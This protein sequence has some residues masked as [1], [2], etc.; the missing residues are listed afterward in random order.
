MA[1]LIPHLQRPMTFFCQHRSSFWSKIATCGSQKTSVDT[2]AIQKCYGNLTH[3]Q[4]LF[5]CCN[6]VV[7]VAAVHADGVV[8]SCC[9]YLIQIYTVYYCKII[10]IIEFYLQYTMK[11]YCMRILNLPIWL[12]FV[13]CYVLH[14]LDAQMT[15]WL[16][17]TKSGYVHPSKVNSVNQDSGPLRLC[18]CLL[19]NWEAL[20]GDEL[21]KGSIRMTAEAGQ[22]GLHC[23]LSAKK[24]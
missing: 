14:A 13:L 9:L 15:R 10:I 17:H 19:W 20:S 18:N 3:C 2:W 16:A 24:K 23:L 11:L 1:I 6:N 7:V 5:V 4:L 8:L 22:A 12:F 21:S